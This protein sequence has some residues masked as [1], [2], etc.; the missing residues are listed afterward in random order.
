[1]FPMVGTMPKMLFGTVPTNPLSQYLT[2]DMHLLSFD[3][4]DGVGKIGGNGEIV[5]WMVRHSSDILDEESTLNPHDVVLGFLR[6]FHD[7]LPWR[8][9]SYEFMVLIVEFC[10]G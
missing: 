10:F 9:F 4:E 1:N 2:A 6:E 7:F 3:K 8:N 5:V